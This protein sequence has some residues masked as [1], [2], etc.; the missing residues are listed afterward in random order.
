MMLKDKGNQIYITDNEREKCRKVAEVFAELEK[1]DIVVLDAGRY[2]FVKLQYYT[3]QK[4]FDDAITFT[5]SQAL[6]DDLWKEWIHTQII[7]LAEEMGIGDIDY[8]DVFMRLPKEKQEELM[9]MRNCFQKKLT[10]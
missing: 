7:L 10:E 3:Y 1:Y 4:G 8:D 2:G 6:F 5:D 9:N